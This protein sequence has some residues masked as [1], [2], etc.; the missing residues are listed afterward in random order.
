VEYDIWEKEENLEDAKKAVVEFKRRLSI[1]VRRQE[2]L[3]LAEEQDFRRRELL[4]KYMAKI[5]YGWD[6]G[7]FKKEYLRKLVSLEEKS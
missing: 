6:D 4:E 2:K 5:L 1:E 3:D 7:K